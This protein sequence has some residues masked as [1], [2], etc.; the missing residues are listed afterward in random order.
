MAFSTI[1][2]N[3][4]VNKYQEHQFAKGYS[5]YMNLHHTKPLFDTTVHLDRDEFRDQDILK[6]TVRQI[7]AA[8]D[9]L[10][11]KQLMALGFV[12]LRKDESLGKWRKCPLC[13]IGSKEPHKCWDGMLLEPTSR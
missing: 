10:I 8:I 11:E 1:N 7:T 9:D 3:P 6:V 4:L 2:G 5:E 13:E 12:K